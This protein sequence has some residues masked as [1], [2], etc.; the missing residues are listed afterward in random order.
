MNAAGT[1]PLLAAAARNNA[2]WCDSVCRSHGLSGVFGGTAWSSPRP[3][4]LY[5]PDAVTLGPDARPADFLGFIDRASPGCSVKDSFATLDLAGDGFAELFTGQW[6]HR[7]ADA[8]PVESPGLRIED[9]T[10]PLRLRRWQAAWHG[11][12]PDVPDVFRPALLG[13][14]AVR[15]LAVHRDGSD[16]GVHDAEPHG[17]A[18]TGD[19]AGG[20]V[21]NLSSGLVGISNV[22]TVADNRS[23]EHNGS[24]NDSTI[25]SKRA[26]WSATVA[27]A[28]ARFPGVP[29]V[30]YESGDDL[31]PALA[32]GFQGIGTLRV[33]LDTADGTGTQDH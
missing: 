8:S 28:A 30:G 10:E 23:Q 2:E 26:I 15:V 1:T 25:Q 3:T 31:A 27:A 19:L 18:G 5:Y 12:A 16:T 17:E 9:V 24:G 13:D 32:T 20:A 33:W 14:P 6:I 11:G 22:F 7:P 4:P 29:L 21:L